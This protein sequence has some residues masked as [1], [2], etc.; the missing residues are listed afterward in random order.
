[1]IRYIKSGQQQLTGSALVNKIGSYI[2]KHLD[3]A[4]KYSKDRNTYDVY[5]TL[6]YEL[7][8]G[9]GGIKNDV[10]EMTINISITTYQNKIRV[11]TIE[12]T[13]QARTLGFDLFKIEDMYDMELA[14]SIIKHKV[15]R[16]I[17]RAYEHYNIL[18]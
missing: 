16:R 14:M 1:M 18:F 4:F 6:L 9:Y 7:K 17:Q 11:N 15:S 8:E 13:P 2:Y 5:V 12:V 10:Q 3:G